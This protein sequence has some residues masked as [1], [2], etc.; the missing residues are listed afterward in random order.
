MDIPGV[1]ANFEGP[2]CGGKGTHIERVIAYLKKRGILY[3]SAREPG[4]T[5]IGEVCRATLKQPQ[6]V[7]KALKQGLSDKTDWFNG[8]LITDLDQP[9]DMSDETELMLF[10]AARG[11][12]FKY[13]V[14]PQLEAGVAVIGDRGPDSTF[15]YQGWTRFQGN[16]KALDFIQQAN[17]F[18]MRDIMPD[19]T[20]LLDLPVAETI[21]RIKENRRRPA[22]LDRFEKD[23][24]LNFFQ[25]IRA[26]YLEAARRNPERI[27]RI[28]ASVSEDEV[29]E[30]IVPHLDRL[31]ANH[32]TH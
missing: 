6:A 18:V 7:Y 2:E 21:K 8:T 20:F 28:D 23:A 26:G 27:K 13:I 5:P 12:Y 30:Q 1:Y 3:Y 14:K 11:D 32:P 24:T 19:C 29:W 10:L 16:Q 25:S 17:E 9:I 4:G 22:D 31:F 15:V